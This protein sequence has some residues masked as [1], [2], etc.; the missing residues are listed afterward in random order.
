MRVFTLCLAKTAPPLTLQTLYSPP[1]ASTT[2]GLVHAEC[3]TPMVLGAPIVS[4]QRLQLSKLVMF[5][6]WESEDAIDQFLGSSH[7]G[8]AFTEGWHVRMTFLR[9]W[10]RVREF[11]SL[12]ELD[13]DNDP[14]LPVAAF[15]LARMKLTQVPR[16]VRWGRPVETLVR[17]NL[18]TTFTL[19]AI[20][21][22]GTIS[23]FSIWNTQQA[24]VDM[25]SGRSSVTEPGRH[26][27][28]M[29][30]RDRKDFH[31]EFT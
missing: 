3:L 10:G 31:H 28:A 18:E 6:A 1:K 14:S 21:H 13:G 5:A 11:E 17:D 26:R 15:T 24:M 9:R 8:A 4:P 16:F 19:A 23:T 12:P 7:L 27:D 30:E 25:V 29:K 2:P 22:P 20:R